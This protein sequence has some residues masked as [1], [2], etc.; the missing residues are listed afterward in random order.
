MFL[1]RAAERFV[2]VSGVS[3]LDTP[4]DSR[5]WASWDYDHD[6][7]SDIALMNANEPVLNLFRNEIGGAQPRTDVTGKFVAVRLEGGNRSTDAS[8]G[9]QRWSN[10]SAI[11]ATVRVVPDVGPTV[12]RALNC[13][14]GLAAQN[15]R[16]L[17][18]GVGQAASSLAL[19]VTWPSGRT[20]SLGP[21]TPGT[22][23]NFWE[24][25]EHSPDGSGARVGPYQAVEVAGSLLANG[26]QE[27]YAPE[28]AKGITGDARLRMFSTMA[29]WCTSCKK[30]LPHFAELRRSFGEDTLAIYGLAVS[31]VDTPEQLAEYIAEH[32]PAYALLPKLS[33]ADR[34]RTEALLG[35]TVRQEVLPSTIVTDAKGMVLLATAGLP[36][37]S[38][39]HQVLSTV[40]SE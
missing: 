14:E 13:G 11:G 6:G 27:V 33:D 12:V 1:N 19:E 36:S 15:S 30:H 29:T 7:R 21:V 10:R 3:G 9:T 22:L 5:A 24:N 4:G 25:P 28:A 16:T 20:S 2:E 37:V 26:P 18:V 38:Q 35:R 8:Q 40:P 23:V 31:E 34:A 39:L 17:I 32:Q